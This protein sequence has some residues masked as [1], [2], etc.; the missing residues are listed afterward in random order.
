[1]PTQR[2]RR[3]SSRNTVA[4]ALALPAGRSPRDTEIPDLLVLRG[5]KLPGSNPR[6]QDHGP[7]FTTI[8][9]VHGDRVAVLEYR[10]VQLK[11]NRAGIGIDEIRHI[12]TPQPADQLW[13][14]PTHHVLSHALRL[15]QV[16]TAHRN[17]G[18]E[19]NPDMK[20]L[21]PGFSPKQL[22]IG[23]GLSN[24]EADS[25]IGKLK[26]LGLLYYRKSHSGPDCWSVN[27]V[28][29][30]VGPELQKYTRA[31]LIDEWA[32]PD[33]E[34]PG[35]RAVVGASV[36][37][38]P[39]S[40][41]GEGD[42]DQE[43]ADVRLKGLRG[44]YEV[45]L[46]Y[47]PENPEIE[48]G[49]AVFTT[50]GPLTE[51]VGQEL[52]LT[53][54]QSSF[55]SSSLGHL[56]IYKST[57]KGKG[58]WLRYIKLGV[59]ISKDDVERLRRIAR[60][61][62]AERVAHPKVAPKGR[63]GYLDAAYQIVQEQVPPGL[64]PD[65]KGFVEFETSGS[66]SRMLSER[67][68]GL[69]ERQAIDLLRDLSSLG[70]L[71]TKSLSRRGTW[72]KLR[73]VKIGKKITQR[74]FEKVRR[75]RR[76]KAGSR[77]PGASAPVLDPGSEPEEIERILAE[78]AEQLNSYSTEIE[79]LKKELKN[80]DKQLEERDARIQRLETELAAKPKVVVPEDL[81]RHLGKDKKS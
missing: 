4:P 40:K 68:E 5:S 45:A 30:A 62:H 71:T 79:G 69:S 3:R 22:L 73:R 8:V 80:R 56:D 2:S 47:V 53:K 49:F 36:L 65:E 67:I 15:L 76:Q 52:G 31:E 6:Y 27:S 33:V 72:V 29:K 13:K 28:Y 58:R 1:M 55:I 23:T 38:N 43:S 44:F 50:P 46:R 11:V 37:P 66:F 9:D 10:T 81:R 77:R 32:L 17:G 61:K 26:S 18:V 57:L 42:K 54:A 35:G 12:W 60:E 24:E 63:M 16:S 14:G 20:R 7:T 78:A 59:E 34:P 74:D 64:K 39:E 48:D 75:I 41:D 51:L 19:D 25:V 21:R 70:L